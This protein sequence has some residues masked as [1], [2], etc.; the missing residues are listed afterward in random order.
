M[1][2]PPVVNP[3][4]SVLKNSLRQKPEPGPRIET[5]HRRIVTDLPA[6]GSLAT[7]RNTDRTIPVVN[8]FQPPIAWERAEGYQV[9]DGQGNCWIDFTSTAVAANSGHGHPAVRAALAKHVESGVLA[10]FNF[11]SSIRVELAERLLELAPPGM[12]KVYFWTVGSEAIEAALRVARI[13]GMRRSPSKNHILTFSGDYHGWTL[14][15]HQLSG[16]SAAKPWLPDPC[17]FIHHLPFP[18]VAAGEAERDPPHWQEFFER[19]MENLAASG[20]TPEQV[21]GVFVESVQGRTGLPLPISYVHALRRWTEQHDALL[22][23]D[24]VQ[25]GFGRTGKWFAFEHYGVRADLIC[26]GK[27]VTSSLP[28]AAVL[29]SA[30]ILD[31]LAPGEIMTTHAA[32]P[33]S[34]AAAL[35]N[36]KVIEDER[37]VEAAEEKGK[38]ARQE[39]RKLQARFPEYI[40]DV[41]GLGL[42][43]AV[44][45]R[46]PAT[47]RPAAELVS[48]WIWAAVRR[49][50]ML[51]YTTGAYIKVC[52]P[53]VIPADA[54]VEGIQALGDALGEVAEM[55]AATPRDEAVSLKR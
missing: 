41:T 44:H 45:V 17:P 19:G 49:G 53:L 14:G 10:Q 4:P 21:A 8:S 39:L 32:H 40:S 11:V 37:L 26:I 2:K 52:P 42:L 7:L 33:L 20:V 27:G 9:Y 46:D 51:F 54:L 25:A 36:L 18:R 1:D 23:F 55:P 30:E 28:L 35:A 29:G 24:E 31:I 38:L 13:W 48:D 5:A 47:G 50:V 6:P 34:C 22:I 3:P 43:Q 16:T 12:E 15:A